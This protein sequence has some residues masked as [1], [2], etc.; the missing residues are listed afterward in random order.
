VTLFANHYRIGNI[1]NKKIY[2]YAL[3]IP[4]KDGGAPS[5]GFATKIWESTELKAALGQFYDNLIFNG[6]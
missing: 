3:T 4:T 2:Q 5:K 1:P 6:T